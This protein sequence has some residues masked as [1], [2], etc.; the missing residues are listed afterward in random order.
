MRPA[1]VVRRGAE[2]LA[3]H[4]VESAQ[5]SAEQ[6]MMSVLGTDR[7]GVYARAE[8]LGA[9]EAKAY[10]RALCLRCTG[11]P[12]QHLTGTAG[13]RGLELVVRPGV[14]VPRPETEILVDVALEMLA[15]VE[16]PVV[17]DVG[18]GTGAV[19]LAVKAE[20]P[21]ASVHATDASVD[22]IVLAR[23]NA[24][25]L[26]LDVHVVQGDLLEALPAAIRP[27]LVVSN[28]P[29]V[30]L[31]EEAGLQ[32]DV[33]AEPRDAV[34]GGPEIYRRLFQGAVSRLVASG[35]V[36]V[37]I[38]EGAGSEISRLAGAVG[39]V[40]VEIRPDLAGR[41]RVVRARRP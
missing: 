33:L 1:E 36:V 16:E 2:Y 28:P 19:A 21:D 20:R 39:F 27:H 13:F 26:G 6:L 8:G 40:D 37:E 9:A 3:R 38:H 14:F 12:L 29:Y 10:G 17:V 7:A 41:D 35:G 5:T 25:R 23:Q 22:A 30:P 15:G 31:A 34:F 24:G 32:P 18:T 4:D 11:S